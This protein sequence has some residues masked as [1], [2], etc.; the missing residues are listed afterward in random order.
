[1]RRGAHIISDTMSSSTEEIRIALEHD[2]LSSESRIAIDRHILLK[3]WAD[4]FEG[5]GL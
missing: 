5:M 1:M 2:D 4:G 3:T